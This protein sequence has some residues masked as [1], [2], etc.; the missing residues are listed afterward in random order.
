MEGIFNFLEGTPPLFGRNFGFGGKN[1]KSGRSPFNICGILTLRKIEKLQNL[2]F[3]VCRH[4]FEKEVLESCKQI[5]HAKSCPLPFG[6][7]EEA[8]ESGQCL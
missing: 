4:T 1:P 3:L 5:T 6:I 2:E 8:R 7:N